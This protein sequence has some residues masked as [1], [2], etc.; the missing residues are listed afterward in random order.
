MC[1]VENNTTVNGLVGVKC[2]CVCPVVH[3]AHLNITQSSLDLL[4][5][6]FCTFSIICGVERVMWVVG[7]GCVHE[8]RK[9]ESRSS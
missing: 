8:D 3:S 4:R 1:D 2:G 9:D 6:M 7:A 5:L